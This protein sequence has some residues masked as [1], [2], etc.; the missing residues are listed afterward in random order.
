VVEN[1]PGKCKT[2]SSNPIIAK[3]KKKK[4]LQREWGGDFLFD[5]TVGHAIPQQFRI[6]WAS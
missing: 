6:R 3:G 1:L 2:W 4:A 5:S